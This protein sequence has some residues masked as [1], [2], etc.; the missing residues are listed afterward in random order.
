MK[1]RKR[2]GESHACMQGG[3]EEGER[4]ARISVTMLNKNRA[5]I[6]SMHG[7]HGLLDSHIF[8]MY[9]YIER[10]PN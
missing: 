6:K 9:L 8:I 1:R 4:D 2:A 7:L 3:K 5:C 10:T